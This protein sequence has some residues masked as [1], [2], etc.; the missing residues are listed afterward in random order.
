MYFETLC[1]W[2]DRVGEGPAPP[3]VESLPQSLLPIVCCSYMSRIQAGQGELLGHLRVEHPEF[4]LMRCDCSARV[5]VAS[6]KV[7]LAACALSGQ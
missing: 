5:A 1:L 4:E 2:V 7:S 3:Q 6:L